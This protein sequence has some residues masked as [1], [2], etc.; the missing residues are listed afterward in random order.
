[1]N[2]YPAV[3]YNTSFSPKQFSGRPKST[4]ATTLK[5][6]NQ[7][8]Q[9]KRVKSAV[10]R[11]KV[12]QLPTSILTKEKRNINHILFKRTE[13]TEVKEAFRRVKNIE[14]GKAYFHKGNSIK[15][16]AATTH[17]QPIQKQACQAFKR[18]AYSN[19]FNNDPF[20]SD[21]N[22]CSRD[23]KEEG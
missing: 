17:L 14:T 9:P 3:G 22:R 4:P 10:R 18:P 21:S 16:I 2:N 5:Q 12:T 6:R 19:H 11:T 8:S 23:T 15:Q 7:H 20:K 1:M 13:F